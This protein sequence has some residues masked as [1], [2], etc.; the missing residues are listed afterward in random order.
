[1]P[2]SGETA[3]YTVGHST[4]SLEELIGLL[5]EADVAILADIR[6][7]PGSRRYPHFNREPL[8]AAIEQSGRRYVWLKA[9]GGRRRSPADAESPNGAWRHPAFRAYADYMMTPAFRQGIAALGQL[10]QEGRTAIMCSEAVYWRCH[11]RLVSDWLVAHGTPVLHIMGPGALRP[12]EVTP[13]A[14]V[15]P[16]GLLVYPAQGSSGPQPSLF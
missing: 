10:A 8:G 16:D 4:R 7:Y 12:H 5:R 6:S 9:L 14:V 3:I 2:S 1:M 11:R 13:E 15:R